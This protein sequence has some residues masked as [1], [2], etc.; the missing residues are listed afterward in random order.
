LE[1]AD[2]EAM[3]FEEFFFCCR[4]SDAS[5]PHPRGD[6]ARVLGVASSTDA[7]CYRTIVQLL[8]GTCL[9]RC[10]SVEQ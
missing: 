3:V 4:A 1:T 7:Q 6:P 8:L 9:L 2:V 10:C 5:P